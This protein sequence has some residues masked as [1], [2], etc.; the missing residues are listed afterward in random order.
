MTK[1]DAYLRKAVVSSYDRKRSTRDHGSYSRS[2]GKRPRSRSRSGSRSPARGHRDRSDYS[3]SSSGKRQKNSK[4]KKLGGGS[5]GGSSSGKYDN[6]KS[7]NKK[8]TIPTSFSEAWYTYLS[9]LAI[10]MVTAVGLVVETIPTIHEIPLGGRLRVCIDNWK[11]IVSND[12]VLSVIEFGYSIPLKHLPSQHKIPKNPPTTGEAHQVLVKEALDLKAKAAVSVVTPVDNQYLS[13]YF[14]VPKPNRVN[15]WRPILNLKYFNVNVKKYKF[16]M[17]NLKSV[18]DWLQPNSYC[19]GLD[20]KDA[21]LHIPIHEGSK[22]FLR[23]HWLGELLEWQVLVFGLTCSPRVITK[24]IKPVIAFLRATWQILISIYIDDI[25][26][27]SRNQ[28]MCSLHCQIVLLVFW[29]LGWSFKFEKCNF[30]PSQ[31]FCHLGF[32]FDTALMTISCPSQ[33]VLKLQDMCRLLHTEARAS[34]LSL[35]RVIGTM[36][37]VKPAT[38]LAPMH[39]RSLQRQ[40]LFAKQG[41][42]DPTKIINLSQ[43]SLEDLTWWFSSDGFAVNCTAPIREMEPTITIYSDANL[44]MGGAHNSRGEFMQRAW[45]EEELSECPHINLLELRAAREALLLTRPGDRVRLHVDSRTAASYIRKQG[46]TKS[47]VLTQEALLLWKESID[48]K[49]TILTPHWLSTTENIMADFLSRNMMGQWELTLAR[50]TFLTILATFQISPSLD[51]F[52][53]CETAQL[54]RYMSWFPDK[55][56]VARDA[57]IN[58]WD[59]ESYLFPPVPLIMK[60]LQRIREQ[61][62]SAVMIIPKWPS[63]LWWPMV[64]EL[65]VGQPLSLPHY[66]ECLEMVDRNRDLPY[67]HPLVAVLLKT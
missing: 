40:L 45:S 46:G 59:K 1:H 51:V 3:S 42:R 52:A 65:M 61:E 22:K 66:T 23:F 33:K 57:M 18:R 17:E 27:Q 56:A 48:L 19:I 28:E 36:E 15:Q 39:Y 53:S 34:V 25:L 14:S 47:F 35:E 54:P 4:P 29:S 6:K 12:W 67:L 63:A 9:P 7:Y 24:V 21:F 13:S 64:Q 41:E 20:I 31:Q 38:P 5:G 37:S 26:I 11:K 43:H 49:I 16:S 30:V 2:G 10:L 58:M 55:Q 44:T 50:S 62:I 32:N 8:G 60:S